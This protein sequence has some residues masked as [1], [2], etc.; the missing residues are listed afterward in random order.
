MAKKV[1]SV[2]TLAAELFWSRYLFG[3]NPQ[4][5]LAHRWA[6]NFQERTKE[7][8]QQ[9]KRDA[10]TED[11][12]A[13]EETIGRMKKLSRLQFLLEETVAGSVYIEQMANMT[14]RVQK[15]QG[16]AK[17][18]EFHVNFMDA[19]G[20]FLTLAIELDPKNVILHADPKS[21]PSMRYMDGL[22][23]REEIDEF[24]S[25]YI[26]ILTKQAQLSVRLEPVVIEYIKQRKSHG[27][28]YRY[29]ELDAIDSFAVNEEGM[30]EITVDLLDHETEDGEW[31][32][33]QYD[34]LIL[35]IEALLPGFDMETFV[36][37]KFT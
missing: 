29:D 32:E 17:S 22:R 25:A 30:I 7:D 10:M 33:E 8:H 9:A 37:S 11:V 28:T 6:T 26:D 13:I 2:E 27:D 20:K 23:L 16:G 15:Y 35:P 24:N 4:Q 19:L 5:A 3:E 12:A 36:N 1:K 31:V 34:T 14:W 21:S 18:S